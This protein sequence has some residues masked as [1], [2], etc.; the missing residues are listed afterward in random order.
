VVLALELRDAARG[1]VGRLFVVDQALYHDGSAPALAAAAGLRAQRPT[2]VPRVGDLGA[3][4]TADA[5]VALSAA[6]TN[7]GVPVAGPTSAGA[8]ASAPGNEGGDAGACG[9]GGTLRAVLGGGMMAMAL[10]CVG[11]DAGALA[12]TTASLDHSRT[13]ANKLPSASGLRSI[14][15]KA[16][17]DHIRSLKT[18]I[19]SARQAA[20]TLRGDLD[21]LK[22]DLRRITKKSSATAGGDKALAA[23][24][25]DAV[26]RALA[27]ADD[28]LALSPGGAGGAGDGRGDD[29]VGQGSGRIPPSSSSTGGG[30]DSDGGSGPALC[31]RGE[32]VI[33][34]PLVALGSACAAMELQVGLLVAGLDGMVNHLRD[35]ASGRDRH[36]AD[37][38]GL[39]AGLQRLRLGSAGILQPPPSSL[40]GGGDGGG[41]P[42]G[43]G[44]AVLT[45]RAV[46][47]A[48]VKAQTEVEVTLREMHVSI[49]DKILAFNPHASRLQRRPGPQSNNLLAAR[50]AAMKSRRR[51]ATEGGAGPRT[52]RS[53]R[54][55]KSQP[56][57]TGGTLR[58]RPASPRLRPPPLATAG[59][60]ALA[61]SSAAAGAG[62]GREA[63]SST[64]LRRASAESDSGGGGGPGPRPPLD[65]RPSKALEALRRDM[66]PP[67][68]AEPA[69]P[70]VQVNGLAPPPSVPRGSDI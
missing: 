13:V 16:V 11:C 40:P 39:V 22:G 3:P 15:A 70:P 64:S 1:C 30:G 68:P 34:E 48:L 56:R 21:C 2:D 50:A 58:Q 8:G 42:L 41:D 60:G 55:R 26:K 24:L 52:S 32:E 9:G 43:S 17:Q 37:L 7:L 66:T 63:S 62:A 46:R 10:T 29:P 23:A 5:M 54:D 27:A 53:D 4:L 6:V 25:G 47:D 31:L 12:S 35:E 28:A 44:P 45:P 61:A 57:N 36:I 20:E 49:L 18:R 51:S 19:A 67:L 33:F 38:A 69:T 59:K 14:E 65:R